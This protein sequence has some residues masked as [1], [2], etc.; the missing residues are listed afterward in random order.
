MVGARFMKQR[1]SRKGTVLGGPPA[2]IG[3]ADRARSSAAPTDQTAS[4]DGATTEPRREPG[5]D[6]AAEV[7]PAAE[8]RPGDALHQ[9]RTER[10]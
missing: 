1:R 4:S 9:P 7:R 8:Q 6:A 10:A 3:V 2:A 5:S